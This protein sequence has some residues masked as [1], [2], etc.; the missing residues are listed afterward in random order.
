MEP[1]VPLVCHR[2]AMESV[3]EIKEALSAKSRTAT[4]D[5]LKS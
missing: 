3:N 1:V 4:L 5:E 2:G